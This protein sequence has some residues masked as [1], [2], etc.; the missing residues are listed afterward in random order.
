M[1]LVV[2]AIAS[3]L[4]F[5][6]LGWVAVSAV[7]GAALTGRERLA[8][9]YPVGAVLL[10]V[11]IYS[12]AHVGVGFNRVNFAMLFGAE[13][14]AL[15][16][17]AWWRHGGG[18]ARRPP[19]S[20]TDRRVWLC[21]VLLLLIAVKV[22]FIV[23]ELLRRPLIAWDTFSVWSLRAKLWTLRGGLLSPLDP[24]YAGSSVRQDYPPHVSL[25]QTWTAVWLG[26]WHD[27]LVNLPW[28]AYYVSALG[29][30]YAV[31]RRRRS[32]AWALGGA[33][34]LAGLP[35]FLSQTAIA[36]YAD[37]ILGTHVLIAISA[38]YLWATE[39]APGYA[40]IALLFTAS[41]P[42]VKLEGLPL[43]VACA[44]ALLMQAPRLRRRGMRW[45]V[46]ALAAAAGFAAVWSNDMLRWMLT[47][48]ELHTEI[49]KPLLVSAFAMDNWHILWA[50]F[51]AVAV[52]RPRALWGTPLGWLLATI[53]VSLVPFVYTFLLTDAAR[54]AVQQTASGRLLLGLAPSVV[55]FVVLVSAD[56]VADARTA[57]PRR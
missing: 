25:L 55:L 38:T 31:I 43:A 18:A 19:A 48:A 4:I 57:P 40:L 23:F 52:L 16:A 6:T 21:A 39:G 17:I 28:G 29:W 13:T 2:G 47:H 12:A 56:A 3:L 30:M 11:S 46:L 49:I 26:G 41:L 45:A 33:C 34:M 7:G 27:V 54:Y 1:N 51:F 35:L 10:S 9:A 44:G 50:L 20:V 14:L 22:S 36:G 15:A 8:L 5:A 37:V 53:L 32:P 24:L 42:F